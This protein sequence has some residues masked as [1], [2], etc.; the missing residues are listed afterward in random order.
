M[1]NTSCKFII[2][3]L[4]GNLIVDMHRI[5]WC[6]LRFLNA[7][8]KIDIWEAFQVFYG[9]LMFQNF[10]GHQ[11]IFGFVTCVFYGTLWKSRC[12]M[13]HHD[14][15]DR[16]TGVLIHQPQVKHT[17]FSQSLFQ[18]PSLWLWSPSN[19]SKTGLGNASVGKPPYHRHYH[20]HH[21]H[22]S[23][24]HHHYHNIFYKSSCLITFLF[25][26]LFANLFFFQKTNLKTSSGLHDSF[27]LFFFCFFKENFE[28]FQVGFS[29]KVVKFIVFFMDPD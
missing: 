28:I 21:H 11:S 8:T 4:I 7:T 26:V 9:A 15:K 27:I 13:Y 1:G 29:N 18:F 17:N 2:H 12:T 22:Y 16:M 5:L 24:H 25:W 6:M 20:H 3:Q 10:A 23:R 19:W 14:P